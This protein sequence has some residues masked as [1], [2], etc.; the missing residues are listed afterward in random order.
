M[1]LHSLIETYYDSQTGD[2]AKSSEFQRLESG[3][4]NVIEIDEFIH[5]LC[6][7]HLKSP[8]ILAF[9]Y[10]IAPPAAADAVQHNLL[11]EMGLDEAGIR[12]PDLLYQLMQAAG[13]SPQQQDAVTAA[14]QAQVRSLCTDPLMFGTIKELGLSVLLEVTCFEWMLARLS[15]R[16]GQALQTHRGIPTDGLAWFSHH[17]E[18]DIRHAEEGI[19][20]WSVAD[21]QTGAL[22]LGIPCHAIFCCFFFSSRRRHTRCADVTGVQTCALPISIRCAS[23][24]TWKDRMRYFH[25]LTDAHLIVWANGVPCETLRPGPLVAPSLGGS[26]LEPLPPCYP[27]ADAHWCQRALARSTAPHALSA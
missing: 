11:E 5:N 10:A 9:L 3:R 18:V 20:M 1:T 6:R 4:L 23:V 14:A 2:F 24:S 26:L 16:M 22:P 25:V 17:S 12:H 7:S 19:V 27:Y 13:F 15:S 21:C 8:Q